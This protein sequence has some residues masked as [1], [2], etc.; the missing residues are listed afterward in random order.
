MFGA[1]KGTAVARTKVPVFVSW[2]FK[3]ALEMGILVQVVIEEAPR[4]KAGRNQGRKG[5]EER[6]L[7]RNVTSGGD[8]SS[9]LILQGA[10]GYE[11]HRVGF[12]L[13]QDASLLH[14]V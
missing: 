5:R 3:L 12:I 2:E 6:N 1:L 11:W 10:P 8:L 13:S 7:S 14:F 4:R 9:S